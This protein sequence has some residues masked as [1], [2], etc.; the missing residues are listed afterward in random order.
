[1][2]IPDVCPLAD[3]CFVNIFS[4]SGLSFHSFKSFFQIAEAL[5]FDDIHLTGFFLFGSI[6]PF[7]ESTFN[8]E[9]DVL[10]KYVT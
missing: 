8:S 5:N 9:K 1:M 2:Y 4:Q 10:S 3:M 7:L 6:L